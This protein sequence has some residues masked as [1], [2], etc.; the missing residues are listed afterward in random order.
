MLGG[1]AL[2]PEEKLIEELLERWELLRRQWQDVAIR[3]FCAEEFP[4]ASP[5]LIDELERVSFGKFKHEIRSVDIGNEVI[6]RLQQLDEVAYVRF[7]S[8]YRRFRDIHEF[9]AEIKGILGQKEK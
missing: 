6:D 7:A 1:I 3:E 8:V 2:M 4:D 9:L 5:E